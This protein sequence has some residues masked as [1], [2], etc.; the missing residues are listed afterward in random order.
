[1]TVSRKLMMTAATGGASPVGQAEYIVGGTFSWTCPAGVTSVCAVCIG[2]GGGGA[3]VNKSD[4]NAGGGGGGLGWTNNIAVTP[5]NSYT[6]EVGLGGAVNG[7][8]GPM[9]LR[10]SWF[11][12]QTTVRGSSGSN[13]GPNQQ[14][15]GGPGLGG[16]YVGD[17]GGNGGSAPS[18]LTSTYCTGAGGAGGYSGDG[19][20]GGGGGATPFN[21]S[22]G[23]GGGAGGGGQGGSNSYAGAGG[24]VDIFGEGT[25]GTGGLS[26]GSGTNDGGFGTGGSGGTDGA[27][28]GNSSTGGAYG[29][30]GGGATKASQAGPGSA[31]AVRIIWGE[32]RAFPSTNTG[33]LP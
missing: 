16:T 20:D 21:G 6:V 18:A 26:V 23:A 15:P 12:N 29:G 33:N 19:G 32:G 17:G 5:G 9:G 24:G 10:P 14:S 2:P 27:L 8:L 28:S 3:G 22:S 25:S 7:I 13:A 30:G 11:I 1:M 4:G 31:G